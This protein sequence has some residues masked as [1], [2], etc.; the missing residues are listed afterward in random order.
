MND[1]P[2]SIDRVRGTYQ[3]QFDIGQRTLLDVLDSE[4]EFFEASRAYAN[5][6]FDLT[7]AQAR[8]LAAM[9]QLM[10]T[11]EVARD[12]IPSLAELGYEGMAQNPEMACGTEG[13]RGTWTP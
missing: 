5:A 12:D 3:Q 8:T 4:N 11:L 1:H 9:G 7:L 2:Q 13:P 10:Q 6:E